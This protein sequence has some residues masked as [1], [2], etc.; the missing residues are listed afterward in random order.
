MIDHVALERR[1]FLRAAVLSGAGV[2][3]AGVPNP[4]RAALYVRYRRSVE[5]ILPRTSARSLSG[6]L[7]G[8]DLSALERREFAPYVGVQYRCASGNTRQYL[9]A[10]GESASGWTFLTGL[11]LWF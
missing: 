4:Y 3:L 10:D 5:P 8:R 2:S 9:R 6:L 11:R 7:Q 1:A